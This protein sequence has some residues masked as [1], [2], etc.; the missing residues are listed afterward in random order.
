MNYRTVTLKAAGELSGS[1]GTEIIPI[2]VKDIISR[3]MI[4]WQVDMLADFQASYLHADIVKI[5]LIDGSDVLHSLNGGQSQGLIIYDRKV[6]T[7]NYKQRLYGNSMASIY[8]I[9]FG[10]FLHDPQLALDPQK[11]NNLQLKITWNEAKA[12]TNA[13]VNQL[14]VK[15]EVFDEKAVSPIGFLMAKEHFSAVS[16]ASG[17]RYIDLP[18]DYILRKLIVQGYYSG[19]EPW[20]S[21]GEVR[22]DE[23]NEKR[24]PFDWDVERYYRTMMGVWMPVVEDLIVMADTDGHA[25]YVTP[26]DFYTHTICNGVSPQT[27][28][29]VYPVGYGK[30]GLITLKSGSG[31]TQTYAKVSGYLPNHCIEFPFGNQKDLDDW[32]DITR[33]GSLR[34]RLKA[35][36]G[37]ATG[38]QAVVLQQLR[39]Y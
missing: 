14:E 4:Y 9:D 10:R 7:L 24:I 13:T 32:Y 20:Y 1:S 39:K 38:T 23:D 8:G 17:Y 2:Y 28:A 16:P 30:G 18:T 33:L 35:G 26:T 19:N 21:V 27:T 5:E 25:F 34:L 12:E 3:I 11:F 31:N 36:S 29:P 37:A 22:L 6:P 15:A